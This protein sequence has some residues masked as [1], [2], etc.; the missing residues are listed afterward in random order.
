MTFFAHEMVFE[1]SLRIS[2]LII[3]QKTVLC[4]S[5]KRRVSPMRVQY[6]SNPEGPIGDNVRRGPLLEVLV[7]TL[8]GAPGS[9]SELIRILDRHQQ[10]C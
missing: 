5:W 3:R 9:G 1:I 2:P 4:A 8:F 7:S 10:E 6:V